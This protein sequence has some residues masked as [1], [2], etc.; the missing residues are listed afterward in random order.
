MWDPVPK[1]S[2]LNNR[3]DRFHRKRPLLSKSS[4]ELLF[5]D[6]FHVKKQSKQFEVEF[7][8]DSIHGVALRDH[9]KVSPWLNE[10]RCLCR[11]GDLSPIPE[12]TER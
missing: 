9:I 8:S 1:T 11:P 5:E 10:D 7:A 3:E 4:P 6:T 2:V 12:P